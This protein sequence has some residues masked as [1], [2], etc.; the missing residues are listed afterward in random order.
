M[1]SGRA[2]RAARR[3]PPLRRADGGAAGPVESVRSRR[4]RPHRRRSRQ[5]LPVPPRLPRQRARSR[6]RLRALAAS[7]DR[8][9]QPTVYAHVATDPGHPGRLALQYWL[10]YVFNEFNNLHEGDWEMIQLNFDARDAREALA[11][12]PVEVGY[13]SHEGAEQADWGDDKLEL[14]ER[15]ASG[16]LSRRGLAREQVRRGALPREL[17]RGGRRLR[18]HPRPARRASPGGQDHTERHRRGRSR[19]SLDRLRGSVGR[20]SEGVLQRPHRAQPEA[21]WTEPIEWSE[22]WRTRSYLPCRP[23]ACSGRAR[24]TSSARRSR[25][26]RRPDPASARPCRDSARARHDPGARRLP[27]HAHDVATRRAAQGGAPAN[28]G[29]DRLGGRPDVRQTGAAVPRHRRPVHPARLLRSRSSRLSSSAGSDWPASIRRES[30]PGALALLVVALGMTLTLLGLA[31][32]QAVTACALVEID[33]GRSIG[34]I[35]AYRFAL[36]RTRPLLRGLG[37]AAG[38]WVGSARPCS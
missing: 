18:R 27:R 13:S 6:L 17:G 22:G 3:R 36:R 5:P 16:R 25:P 9:G 33:A 11:E 35:D 29:A 28:L 23:A 31:L 34:P 30:R 32:L 19:V 14:V 1:R 12:E 2:V 4:D 24:P 38:V 37:V 26:D 10:F 21:Q 7:A 8:V 20:A 15:D